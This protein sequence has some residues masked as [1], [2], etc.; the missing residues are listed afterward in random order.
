[1]TIQTIQQLK[2]IS[3]PHP[4]DD[5]KVADRTFPTSAMKDGG[6]MKQMRMSMMSMVLM[7]LMLAAMGPTMMVI[8]TISISLRKCPNLEISIYG[9]NSICDHLGRPD[10][11]TCDPPPSKQGHE[12]TVTCDHD[13]RS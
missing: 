8:V 12:V 10:I 7:T 11:V 3:F 2:E 5:V 9:I 6:I 1:M 4:Q 13:L